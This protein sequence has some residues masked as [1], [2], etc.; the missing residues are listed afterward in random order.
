MELI[1]LRGEQ[2][3]NEILTLQKDSEL[4]HYRTIAQINQKTEREFTSKTMIEEVTKTKEF[5]NKL[6]WSWS[7]VTEVLFSQDDS[8]YWYDITC[9]LKDKTTLQ[10]MKI[11]ITND[12]LKTK[13]KL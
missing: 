8:V 10:E 5:C 3:A 1:E 12:Y 13:Q 4:R 7:I 6:A 9:W 11:D 2:T